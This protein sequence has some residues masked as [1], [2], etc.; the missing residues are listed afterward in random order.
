MLFRSRKF[1]KMIYANHFD[2]D[3]LE[4]EQNKKELEGRI[5][6]ALNKKDYESAKKIAEDLEKIVESM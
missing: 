4:K 6:R 2:K 5:Y 1:R 3:Y